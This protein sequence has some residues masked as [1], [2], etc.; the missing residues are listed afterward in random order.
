LDTENL[1]MT[2]PLTVEI[3]WRRISDPGR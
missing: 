2:L 3:Q 1:A